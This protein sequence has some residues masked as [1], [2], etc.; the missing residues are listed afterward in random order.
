MTI[1]ELARDEIRAL[2]AYDLPTTRTDAIRL[3]AN[4]APIAID[5]GTTHGLNHYPPSR[6]HRLTE[7]MA[8]F[9]GVLPE[10]V[11]VTRGS[12]EGID[13]L[14]RTF[15]VP[16]QDEV[17]ITPPAF[18]LYRVYAA[19]QGAQ[20]IEIPLFAEEQFVLDV[21]ALLA[22][23][24]EASKLIFL[25]SPN[26]PVGTSIPR[27][28]LIRIA[29]STSEQS[30]VVVDEAYIEFSSASSCSDLVAEIDNLVVLRTLSKGHALAGARCGCVIAAPEVIALLDVVLPPYAISTPVAESALNALAAEQVDTVRAMIADIILERDRLAKALRSCVVVDYVWPSDANYL[31]VRFDDLPEILRRLEDA[32]ILIRTFRDVPGLE[33][34]ARVTIGTARE[35]QAF[36]DVVRGVESN[37]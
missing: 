8:K 23:T 30:I 10:N 11:L 9:Y 34:C 24:G 1:T 13:L 4:E 37:A 21:D 32:S 15:C 5:S 7:S 18:E 31:L 29:K 12:S 3:N 14:V 27:E 25:C 19:I 20:V 22:A 35:N 28:Q 6:P 2:R 17:L 26:N 36:L 33:G 16:G